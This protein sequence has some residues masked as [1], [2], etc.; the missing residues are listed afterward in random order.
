[1]IRVFFSI[2]FLGCWATLFPQSGIHNFGN[3]QLHQKGHLGFHSD[4]INDGSFE[5]NLGL[6]G[7]YDHEDGLTISGAF[8]PTFY[9]LELALEN[10]LQLEVTI[11]V[12]NSLNFIY[13]NIKTN[14]KY[15]NVYAKFSNKAYYDGLLNLSKIDGYAAVL[16]QKDFS[17]PVGQGTF[18][19]PLQIHFVDDVFLAKC[20]YF[21]ENPEYSESFVGRFDLSSREK[22]L[23]TIC[24]QEFWNLNTSGRIQITLSW[25]EQTNLNFYTSDLS[26]ITVTG[27]SK[28]KKQ[29]EDLGNS[30]IEGN[31]EKGSIMSQ[32]FNANDYEIFTYGFVED[33]DE[34]KPGNYAITPNGDGINDNFSLK[35]IEQSP[36]NELKIFNRA[37]LMVFEK[38]NYKN[39]F[40]GLG[41]RNILQSNTYLPE[42]V[43]F[44]LLDLKDIN[45]SYQGYF[46]LAIE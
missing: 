42:G 27:W 1:M 41:N 15:K 2:L 40:Q 12:D 46:Y 32:I 19:K 18:A 35:I 3:L 44:Y 25:D 6:I 39:E 31:L 34:E 14:R 26:R 4:L 24:P 28:V 21:M 43:Y 11:R 29:W 36:N 17:F 8:N 45:R 23:S 38:T 30:K 10:D 5:N 7:F 13:G 9:D 37:G 33:N 16:G 20:A 22:E